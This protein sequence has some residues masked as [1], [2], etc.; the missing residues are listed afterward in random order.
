MFYIKL[1]KLDIYFFPFA[2]NKKIDKIG[3][4]FAVV[5]AWSAAD[6][7]RIRVSPFAC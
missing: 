5:C 7:E 2:Y 3:K 6:H 4:G 1:G